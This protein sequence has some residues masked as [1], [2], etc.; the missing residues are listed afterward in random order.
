VT[1]DSGIKHILSEFADDTQLCRV[2]DMLEGRDAI[3]KE[4]DRFEMWACAN[5]TKF[6]KTKCKALHLDQGKS[7]QKYRLGME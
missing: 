4:I 2:V 1:E 5:L 3:Q 7:K 6:N